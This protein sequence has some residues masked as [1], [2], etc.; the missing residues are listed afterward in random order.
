MY[1]NVNHM[2]NPGN[3]QV[4]VQSPILQQQQFGNFMG[5]QNNPMQPMNPI[6]QQN[7]PMMRPQ[8]PNN[9]H[10]NPMLRPQ[11]P[12]NLHND[13]MMRPQQPN[14]PQLNSMM[15]PQQ[16]NIQN[17]QIN[18]QFPPFNQINSQLNLMSPQQ[19]QQ[20]S[21]QQ[22]QIAYMMQMNQLA[23]MQQLAQMNGLTSGLGTQPLSASTTNP[24]P[25][26]LIP[27]PIP[28]VNEDDFDDDDFG[29]FSSAN[30]NPFPQSNQPVVTSSVPLPLPETASSDPFE[31]GGFVGS[32]E[33]VNTSPPNLNT[34]HTV[35]SEPVNSVAVDDDT[36][37]DFGDFNSFNAPQP[38]PIPTSKTTISPESSPSNA[39]GTTFPASAPIDV[40]ADC[41]PQPIKNI[42]QAEDIFKAPFQNDQ[43]L[44]LPSLSHAAK[45]SDILSQ[46][47]PVPA[48]DSSL[49]FFPPTASV[50]STITV[51]H[52]KPVASMH[53][54]SGA[55]DDDFGDFSGAPAPSIP[56]QTSKDMGANMIS[57]DDMS[58]GFEESGKTVN[59]K[60]TLTST[61]PTADDEDDFGD[62]DNA[63][64]IAPVS[65]SVVSPITTLQQPPV[66]D[67]EDFGEFA[68][69]PVIAPVI[70]T[71]P[72][73]TED[74]EWGDF[75]S[76]QGS[77]LPQI[78]SVDQVP[79][80][81]PVTKSKADMFNDVFNNCGIST[82]SN[83]TLS[84]PEITSDSPGTIPTG[85][86][87][88]FVSA[89]ATGSAQQ[90]PAELKPSP[91]STDLTPS[92]MQNNELGSSIALPSASLDAFVDDEEEFAGFESY[93]A[94]D[95]PAAAAIFTD[96]TFE[97][98]PDVF[99]P[100]PDSLPVDT[101]SS[102]EVI[103]PVQ[104]ESDVTINNHEFGDLD[105]FNDDDFGDFDSVPFSATTPA[106]IDTIPVQSNLAFSLPVRDVDK[107]E[108]DEEEFGSFDVAVTAVPDVS[109]PLSADNFVSSVESLDFT[110]VSTSDI[111]LKHESG[112]LQENVDINDNITESLEAENLQEEKV[113]QEPIVPVL[114]SE[115]DLIGLWS[116]PAVDLKP[117]H[118]TE[119]LDETVKAEHSD[120][121]NAAEE[122]REKQELAQAMA[123]SLGMTGGA[124]KTK[125]LDLGSIGG[126]KL[127][128]LDID[129]DLDLDL[130]NN[131]S[132][133]IP[134][135]R[136]QL[137]ARPQPSDYQPQSILDVPFSELAVSVQSETT[138]SFRSCFGT[139]S[140]IC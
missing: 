10:N 53:P 35:V 84:L 21:P 129:I 11:Q 130:D 19:L 57:F 62:F 109:V 82:E 119:A 37:D 7:N 24:I 42:S 18:N 98:Q 89:D 52:T 135:R 116:M 136:S 27:V 99:K 43:I 79:Y 32:E 86:K 22:L 4:Q 81:A 90:Q 49:D 64:T 41:M 128:K 125:T 34:K 88:L 9:P 74:D 114:K 133:L 13:P 113:P 36:D 111:K 68:S 78:A 73:L 92:Q 83:R 56:A 3:Q 26:P 71:Q 101:S 77:S 66:E 120:D 45:E 67:D 55:D 108:D 15:R 75:N 5:T 131:M 59:D 87:D 70:S 63:P 123:M 102:L 139:C 30:T 103:E 58:F 118:Q 40:F 115:A 122:E 20:M 138:Q 96:P 46:P 124:G 126:L 85:E 104:S 33:N 39:P 31:F 48:P 50:T 91:Y 110:A 140:Q 51:P 100:N 112:Q 65:T 107:T 8:Q 97:T 14:N 44:S 60:A 54:D 132:G 1:N 29:D 69:V 17:S 76:F 106:V 121:E 38:S 117:T 28:S 137:G 127:D 2:H 6:S 105:D 134:F 25:V 72:S 95:A 47:V 61:H 94:N 12:N 80:I 23:Q 93:N 16:Q